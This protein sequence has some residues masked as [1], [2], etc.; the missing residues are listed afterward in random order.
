MRSQSDYPRTHAGRNA[1]AA[2]SLA[3][4][5]FL[6]VSVLPCT[7]QNHDV[8]CRDGSGGFQAEFQSTGEKVRVGAAREDGL[9]SRKCEADL[10][11]NKLN[12]SVATNAAQVDLDA[13]GVDLGSGI[14][15]AAF[16]VKQ[17]DSDCCMQYQVYSLKTPPRLL[18]TITGGSY[19]SAADKDLDGRVE[20]WTTDAAA[21]DGFDSLTLGELEPPT[22]ILRFSRGKLLDV[23]PE[24]QSYFDGELER[25]HASV[26][27]SDLREFKESDGRLSPNEPLSAERMHY[28]RRIKAA[29]LEI[30]WCYL[31]SGRE[32]QAWRSLAEMWPP[33]D[34]S[35]IHTAILNARAR[36]IGA[37]I[38]DSS[39]Q[40]LGKRKYH[41]MIADAISESAA[42]QREVTP[43]EPIMLT[44]PP[45]TESS[46]QD[47]SRSEAALILVLD[48]A[49]K[50]RS[51]DN[52]G[53][54]PAD[55]E[56]IRATSEWK[57]I[58][59]FK[60]GR[61]VA[62]RMRLTVSLKQ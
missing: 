43:P 15:I 49:G 57:F 48:S 25:L 42:R 40:T 50:V 21:V 59:A 14:P 46:G 7:A 20:I 30:I 52:Y 60:D 23:S 32:Q 54:I 1:C 22:I 56:L 34:V 27:G 62:C 58:P 33:S 6:C 19:F 18:R 28:L 11:W 36:G 41:A 61:P 9:A 24:F 16:Q 13:F 51:V 45:L 10:G 39:P 29:V 2:G 44:R 53:K 35:R 38:N 12:L 47:A 31:Y 37:Q 8:L 17:S 5:C 4:F 3:V 26:R 55:P